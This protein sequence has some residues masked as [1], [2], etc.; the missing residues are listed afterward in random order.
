[1]GICISKILH[2]SYCVKA[3][4]IGRVFLKNMKGCVMNSLNERLLKELKNTFT[5]EFWVQPNNVHQI[6]KQ[7]REERT[8]SYGKNYIIGP[9][10]GDYDDEAGISVSVGI[11]GITVF[12]NTNKK[13]YAVLV[14]ESKIDDLTHIAVVYDDK[15]PYLFINGSFIKKV[16]QSNKKSVYPSGIIAGQPGLFFN[17]FIKENKNLGLQQNRATTKG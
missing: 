10:H 2:S 4:L 5:Y 6:D 8:N 15:V 1:M 16:E 7:S 11:N 14:N 13:I 17:G 9:G 3:Q 12:E